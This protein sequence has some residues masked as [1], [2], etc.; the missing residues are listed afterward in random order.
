MV[1]LRPAEKKIERE[2]KKEKKK[3]KSQHFESSS[4]SGK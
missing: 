4:T 1:Y 2:R 3:D